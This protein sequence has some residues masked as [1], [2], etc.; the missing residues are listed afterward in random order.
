[1]RMV[2]FDMMDVMNEMNGIKALMSG[3]FWL[4]H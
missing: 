3:V 2:S 1:M 4:Q